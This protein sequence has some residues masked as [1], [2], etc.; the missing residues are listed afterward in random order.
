MEQ[1]K[2][3]SVTILESKPGEFGRQCLL[4]IAYT[5]GHESFGYSNGALLFLC[6]SDE[7]HARRV[8]NAHE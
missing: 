7:A 1:R 5:D 6:G 3:K 4:H 2:R 8:F